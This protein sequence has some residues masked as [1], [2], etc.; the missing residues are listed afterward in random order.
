MSESPISTA[1][2]TEDIE[3]PSLD[4]D[5]ARLNR[6]HARMK[7]LGSS[8]LNMMRSI[9]TSITDLRHEEA[10]MDRDEFYRFYMVRPALLHEHYQEDFLSFVHD[11]QTYPKSYSPKKREESAAKIMKLVTDDV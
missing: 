3:G 9:V 2:A 10:G 8:Y 1:K 4:Y 6:H 5:N 7:A 11:R